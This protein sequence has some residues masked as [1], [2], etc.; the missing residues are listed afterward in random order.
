MDQ[1]CP[2]RFVEGIVC[3]LDVDSNKLPNNEDYE[4][5]KLIRVTKGRYGFPL[6][7]VVELQL[8]KPGFLPEFLEISSDQENL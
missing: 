4:F 8:L 2:Q 1:I 3:C 6:H 7:R 5:L